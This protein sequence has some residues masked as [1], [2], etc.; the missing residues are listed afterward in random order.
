MNLGFTSV[1]EESPQSNKP[2]FR[3]DTLHP[4]TNG[5]HSGHTY[6]KFPLNLGY[7]VTIGVDADGH[8]G[9]GMKKVNDSG[10][11]G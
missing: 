1:V 11:L 5:S 10:G 6:I 7:R 4:Y 9:H 3:G 2:K 8:G